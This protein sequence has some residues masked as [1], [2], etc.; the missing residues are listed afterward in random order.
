MNVPL[1]NWPF[2]VVAERCAAVLVHLHGDDSSEP[3][4]LKTCVE[5]ARTR[6]ETDEV[7]WLLR[8]SSQI[9]GSYTHS[10]LFLFTALMMSRM[11]FFLIRS[12][13]ISQSVV[14]AVMEMW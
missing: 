9:S 11:P 14:S 1:D 3:S 2:P 6:K 7:Q 4:S 10:C 13:T 8:G 5:S 12:S